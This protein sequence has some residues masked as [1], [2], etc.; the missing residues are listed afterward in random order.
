MRIASDFLLANHCAAFREVEATAREEVDPGGCCVC[1]ALS[2]ERLS[3]LQQKWPQSASAC[4]MP[5]KNR[6]RISPTAIF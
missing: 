3:G 1:I 5:K 6:R 2:K 4:P